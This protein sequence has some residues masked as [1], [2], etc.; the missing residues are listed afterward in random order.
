M[1]TELHG[2]P[3]LMQPAPEAGSPAVGFPAL[4]YLKGRFYRFAKRSPVPKAC[5]L[6]EGYQVI[7]HTRHQASWPQIIAAGFEPWI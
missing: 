6:G 3:A 2:G 1:K 5:P 4:G 7:C